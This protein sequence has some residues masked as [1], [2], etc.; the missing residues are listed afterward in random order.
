MK[1]IALLILIILSLFGCNKSGNNQVP[2][3]EEGPIRIEAGFMCGWGAG[4]DSLY[5]TNSIIKYVY[6]V[7]AQS[8]L[9]KIKKT[10]ITTDTEWENILNSLNTGYFLKLN[11]NTCNVCVD[12]CDEWISIQDDQMSHKI[13]FDQGLKID[14]LNKLQTIL[15]QFR[16]E[17]RR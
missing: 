13:R 4:E 12:G 6:Y 8:R 9:P 1:L 14:S 17:F 10:R 7:P 16:S 2:N 3:K 5:I 11:Y 15:E